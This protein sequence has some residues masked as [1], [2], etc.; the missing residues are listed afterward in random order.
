MTR[1]ANG[2][3]TAGANGQHIVMDD[4]LAANLE[5]EF[6]RIADQG[7]IGDPRGEPA[8]GYLRVSSRGQAEEGRSGLPRQLENIAGKAALEGL[9]IAWDMIYCDDHTG[10]T[11]EDR[12]ALNKLL[13]EVKAK[14]RAHKLVMEYPDRMSRDHT[15]RYGYLR[16]Q[17]QKAGVEYEYWDGYGS[18]IERSVMGT[19]S[20]QGMR[21]EL[22]RMYYGTLKKAHSGRITA[23]TP[24]YG[25]EFE[26]SDGRSRADPESNWRKDTHYAILEEEADV[27]RFMYHQLAYEGS[28]MLWL[29]NY[30]NDRRIT[31]PKSTDRWEQTLISK[32]VKNPVYKG[33]FVAH[34]WY[35]EKVWSE[36]SQCMTTRKFERP[37]EEW[38]IVPVPPIVDEKTWELAQQAIQKNRTKSTRNT[39]YDFLLV[40]LLTCAECGY[41]FC[42][43][44]R[45]VR[46]QKKTYLC[47]T[48]RCTGKN[49]QLHVVKER[50]ACTQS[51]IS[52]KIL[53]PLVWQAIMDLLTTPDLLTQAMD[54][55]YADT[56]MELI[57]SQME[58]IGQQIQ[59]REAEDEKLYRAYMKGAFDEEEFAAR[60]RE[61]KIAMQ[62]LQGE[63]EALAAQIMS[64]EEFNQRRRM[65]TDF[66]EEMRC[67]LCSVDVPFEVKRRIVKMIVDGIELNVNERWFRIKGV[68]K[69]TF[70]LDDGRFVTTPVDRDSSIRLA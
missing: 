31:P 66:V 10:F 30:L 47:P 33:Q 56:G 14:P 16:E 29:A 11:F 61:V 67:N 2:K 59:Q 52:A 41:A 35:Y 69:G 58:F 40:N 49:N 1:R 37:K 44:T 64:Q 68:L 19:I 4:E 51:Q 45:K 60:R 43:Q 34:R 15:W 12:P 46:P 70:S 23:K 36:R 21:K 3:S 53:D 8:Y 42:A 57:H 13:E 54:E 20:E 63:R 48:Y 22:E 17:F 50:V 5:R 9:A 38:I 6:K 26:D 7:V 25:F 18:E 27:M 32:M 62:T 55:Y 39:R 28:T 24:A 65:V